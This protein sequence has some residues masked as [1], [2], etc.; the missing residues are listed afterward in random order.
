MSGFAGIRGHASGKE[1]PII[2]S[3]NYDFLLSHLAASTSSGDA[4]FGQWERHTK[5]IGSKLLQKMGFKPGMGLGKNQQGITAP[6]EV[7]K[8]PGTG[9][10]GAYGPETKAP[11]LS[12]LKG[13][14]EDDSMEEEEEEEDEE[15]S[16]HPWLK[17]GEKKPKV[18]KVRVY[19][20]STEE[21]ISESVRNSWNN[22]GENAPRMKIID[23]TGPNKRVLSGLS[24]L[25]TSRPL[26]PK[27]DY[28]PT[29]MNTRFDLPELKQNLERLVRL[30]QNKLT[31]GKQE[32]QRDL[33]QVEILK[34]EKERLT[35]LVAEEEWQL[36]QLDLYDTFVQ[37]L[38]DIADDVEYDDNLSATLQVILGKF[39]T[40]YSAEFKKTFNRLLGL[41]DLIICAFGP[42]LR[43][44][45]QFWRPFQAKDDT[46]LKLFVRLKALVCRNK[47]FEILLWDYWNPAVSRALQTYPTMKE[48]EPVVQFIAQWQPVIPKWLFDNLVGTTLMPRMVREVEQWEPSNDPMPI[49]QWILPWPITLLDAQVSS[50]DI[51][52]LFEPIYEIIRQKLAKALGP[53]QPTTSDNSVFQMMKLWKNVFTET[54]F[55]N[56]IHQNIVPKLEVMMASIRVNPMNQSML[57]WDWVMSWRELVPL[58]TIFATIE[59]FF[60]PNWLFTLYNWLSQPMVNFLEVQ[61]WYSEWKDRLS[62][63]GATNNPSIKELLNKALMM[64]HHRVD[65]NIG[66]RSFTEYYNP[67]A[68]VLPPPSRPATEPVPAAPGPQAYVHATAPVETAY[69]Q[70]DAIS[71]R[72][73]VEMKASESGVLFM[74]IANRF[75]DGKQVFQFGQYLVFIDNQVLF[76]QKFVSGNRVWVPIRLPELIDLCRV[77]P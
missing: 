51:E 50:S 66:L 68:T 47:T 32:Y 70:S 76:M 27:D 64:M 24:Q 69:T 30:S 45:L 73:M 60:F 41:D 5:G 48:Y 36:Q 53:W 10:I 61:K 67:H 56:F 42:R 6:I 43:K 54:A 14:R 1:K 71:F 17:G 31:K 49:D 13:P 63:H 4:S 38:E 77:K 7:K 20:K 40:F 3:S 16:G 74:P 33:K 15:D 59:K 55:Q 62:E 65:P 29:K 39:E 18:K 8:R 12:K 34:E 21:I 75:Q 19:T 35:K 52:F 37:E 46:I 72:Q 57:E 2:E 58:N 28:T 44:Q 9:A 23:M 25:H 26:K 11:P 22:N